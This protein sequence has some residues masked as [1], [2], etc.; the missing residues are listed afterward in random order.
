RFGR[1]QREL[2]DEIRTD[3]A[4]LRELQTKAGADPNAITQLTQKVTWATQVFDD[5]RQA[6]R[7]ACDVPTKIEQRLFSLARAIQKELG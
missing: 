7:Y 2:A 6:A 1:R 5:R 3:A 4:S